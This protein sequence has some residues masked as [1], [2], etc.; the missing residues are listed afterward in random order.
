[1]R[2]WKSALPKIEWEKEATLFRLLLKT[3]PEP[4]SSSSE[5]ATSIMA[6]LL[7][8]SA[9]DTSAAAFF[10]LTKVAKFFLFYASN[11]LS[12]Q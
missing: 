5:A 10:C 7:W 3:S 4:V 8:S 12:E 9:G 11:M 1:M 6:I 2:K